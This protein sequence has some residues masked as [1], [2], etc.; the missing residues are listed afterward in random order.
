MVKAICKMHS[1]AAET[2][3]KTFVCRA[4]VPP[5]MGL[6]VF[7]EKDLASATL[8]V[9]DEYVSLYM[10]ADTWREFASIRPISEYA[11]VDGLIENVD[12]IQEIW[13]LDG[14]RIDGGSSALYP[15]IY[16]V[17]KGKT[18]KKLLVR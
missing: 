6:S 14:T 11:S 8:Y 16:I 1:D 10:Y 3:I 2:S 7:S 12:D 9:P 15:G 5:V 13:T 17:R 18:T 4:L